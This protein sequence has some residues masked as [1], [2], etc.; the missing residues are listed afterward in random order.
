[1]T[2][3]RDTNDGPISATRRAVLWG[4]GLLVLAAGGVV[5]RGVDRG[6]FTTATGQAYEPWET[7][8]DP[9]HAGTPLAL[10]AAGILAAN[11]H[12]TQPW[13]F[14]I[15]D[16]EIVLA[17]DDRRHLGHFDPYRRELGLSLGCALENMLHAAP[18][19]GFAPELR[20]AAGRTLPGPD[21][22]MIAAR[23]V[24]ALRPA[25]ETASALYEAIPDRHTHRGPYDRSRRLEAPSQETMRALVEEDGDVRLF[26]FTDGPNR[27]TFDR[28]TVEATE[29]IITD[30]PMVAD[31][32]AWFR[33]TRDEVNTHRDGVTLD[34]AGLSAPVRVIAK[35]L[36][37]LSSEQTN[38]QWLASTRDVHLATAPLT[39]FLATRDLYTNEAMIAGGRAW[40]RLHLWATSQGIA[41]HPLNQP[42]E[43]VDRQRET[44]APPAMARALATLLDTDAWKPTFSFRAGYPARVTFPS[45]RRDLQD[46]IV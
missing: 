14:A 34:A 17:A 10:V 32:D 12:N 23:A 5:W 26:L 37:P 44:G 22:T 36:P 29:Q 1:M 15:S 31:S 28:L 8:N 4:G 42:L 9:S 45:P 27:E 19:N 38:A 16:D 40:Q 2:Q 11:A 13:L 41:M 35:L 33:M 43:I 24:L 6:A 21:G 18:A 25:R 39:G 3:T 20:L 46:V 30:P 7:W